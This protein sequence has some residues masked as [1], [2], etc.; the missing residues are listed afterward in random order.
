[1]N[2]PELGNIYPE[3]HYFDPSIP[4]IKSENN[5]GQQLEQQLE[6]Q[7]LE[8]DNPITCQITEIKWD[9]MP[10]NTKMKK[11]WKNLSS[12]KDIISKAKYTLTG[13]TIFSALFFTGPPLIVAGTVIVLG[14]S[15]Y[16][17]HKIE[18]KIESD[19]DC[20]NSER[21]DKRLEIKKEIENDLN[22]YTY[23]RDIKKYTNDIITDDEFNIIFEHDIKNKK[24]N[25]GNF[26]KK[27]GLKCFDILSGT[28]KNS[29]KT[30]F[31]VY[32]E[33]KMNLLS[34]S[35]YSSEFN[36]FSMDDDE[37]TRTVTSW[38][39][40]RLLN[41]IYT[42]DK[43]IEKNGFEYLKWINS[44]QDVILKQMLENYLINL[45]IGYVELEKKFIECSKYISSPMFKF[46]ILS[47]ELNKCINGMFDYT[48]LKQRNGF[49][50]I[51]ELVQTYPEQK[52]L[53][54]SEFVKLSYDQ[55]VSANHDEDR[56]LYLIGTDEIKN[57]LLNRWSNMT[58]QDILQKDI[59]FYDSIEKIFT[60]E[61]WKYKVVNDL[62]NMP[63]FDIAKCYPKLFTCKI[64]TLDCINYYG[65]TIKNRVIDEIAQLVSFNDLMNMTPMI[66]FDLSIINKNTDGIS[67]LVET[68]IFNHID[69]CLLDKKSAQK[70]IIEKYQLVPEWLSNIYYKSKQEIKYLKEQHTASTELLNYP[71]QKDLLAQKEN[72]IHL[73]EQKMSNAKRIMEEKKNIYECQQ[74][75]IKSSETERGKLWDKYNKNVAEISGL[76]NSVQQHGIGKDYQTICSELYST[77]TNLDS[78]KYQLENDPV[79][80][81][82][83]QKNSTLEFDI[84]K[85]KSQLELQNRLT[86]LESDV[87]KLSNET[88]ILHD[89]IASEEFKKKKERL[90]NDLNSN[91]VTGIIG[92][93]GAFKENY[94]TSKSSELTE[95]CK[96]EASFKEK[97]IQL[98]SKKSQIDEIK[99]SVISYGVDELLSNAKKNLESE[100]QRYNDRTLRLKKELHYDTLEKSIFV[101]KQEKELKNKINN[102]LDKIRDLEQSNTKINSDIRRIDTELLNDKYNIPNFKFAFDTANNDYL[103]AEQELMHHTLEAESE[104]NKMIYSLEYEIKI[105]ISESDKKLDSDINNVINNVKIF[106]NKNKFNTEL[107]Q[108]ELNQSESKQV[109]QIK[110][111]TQ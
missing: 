43:F 29:L 106:I 28:N 80:L 100:K 73:Y 77:E 86:R 41:G 26:I 32:I 82:I 3:L 72:I 84:D 40:S 92:V 42:F 30:L 105:K 107:N 23:I 45:D 110:Q 46:L 14:S 4:I 68:Y 22:G 50:L 65:R 1:M 55:L 98:K 25:Y 10:T 66:L 12:W 11:S 13:A 70:D 71:Y 85:Y 62:V 78:V 15:S 93:I 21:M 19:Q 16:G 2:Y 44:E 60:P 51:F 83:K 104:Y 49:D 88:K 5:S 24:M 53:Y 39:I 76:N 64:L 89:K 67:A 95:M 48:I 47:R 9:E 63:V 20:N 18:Q 81:L 8:Q 37:I 34:I 75:K 27:H 54:K 33:S 90:M 97:K 96:E 111:I 101:L 58:T 74:N 56:K 6:E 79:C 7:Q 38:E 87:E 109:E 17:C 103:R 35:N 31:M 57:I 69:N 91:N 61:E 94:L 36:Y 102:F 108:S 52:E 99:L 59:G